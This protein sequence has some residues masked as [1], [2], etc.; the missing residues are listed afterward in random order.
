[1]PQHTSAGS[2][3]Y[4]TGLVLQARPEIDTNEFGLKQGTLRFLL[5]NSRWPT[6]EPVRGTPTDQFT[7]GN[8]ITADYLYSIRFMAAQTCRWTPGGHC[9]GVGILE[10]VVQGAKFDPAYE[11]GYVTRYFNT[12]STTLEDLTFTIYDMASAGTTLQSRVATTGPLNATYSINEFGY[13][14]LRSV[15]YETLTID[16]GTP[17][18]NNKVLV[19]DQANAAHN[20][21]YVVK[22]IGKPIGFGNEYWKMIRA[23]TMDEAA[24]FVSTV[25]VSIAE[26]T[27]N[28][29]TL[30]NL[31]PAG[32]TFVVGTSTVTFTSATI[33]AV[34]PLYNVHLQY[35]SIDLHFEYM[36]LTHQQ[37]LRYIQDDY[38]V[39]ALDTVFLAPGLFQNLSIEKAEAQALT[40]TNPTVWAAID[41]SIW[42]GNVFYPGTSARFEQT[43]A[44]VYWHVLETASIKI[45]AILPDIG[46]VA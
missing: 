32:G 43:P 33:G 18:V 45:Q 21:L 31:V 23:A 10:V 44:G 19:K 35:H 20:G 3:A 11:G 7:T 27:A 1:M 15:F 38:T 17:S 41:R 24:E 4:D 26:G 14:E 40:S 5:G 16:G 8:S 34:T 39:D 6:L 13:A 28:S 37:A 25:Y 29:G 30:W 46:S 9:P 22:N 12:I 36:S 2:R 42:Q